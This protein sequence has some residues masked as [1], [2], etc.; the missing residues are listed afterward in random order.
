MTYRTND[1]LTVLADMFQEVEGDNIRV[2]SH[3][4]HHSP[5]FQT[6]VHRTLKATEHAKTY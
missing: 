6:T 4:H 3:H 1:E 2:E 5:L